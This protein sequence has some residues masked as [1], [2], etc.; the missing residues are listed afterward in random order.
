MLQNF[1]RRSVELP[2]VSLST[3]AIG[4]AAAQRELILIMTETPE[5]LT[6]SFTYRADRFEPATIARLLE[7]YERLLAAVAEDPAI[8]LSRLLAGEA[9][10]SW[11]RADSGLTLEARRAGR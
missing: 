1:P 9:Q 5:G 10:P 3:A 2:G 7:L 8:P 4:P 11:R 6:A